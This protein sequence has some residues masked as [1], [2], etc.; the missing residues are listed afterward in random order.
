VLPTLPADTT[1]HVGAVGAVLEVVPAGCRQGGLQLLRPFPVGPCESPDLVRHRAEVAEHLP[2]WLAV[3][4]RV[5]ELLPHFD[6]E[7]LLR[8][9]SP[10]SSLVVGMRSTALGAV[11]SGVPARV[12]A[13]R[14][15]PTHLTCA[16]S[17]DFAVEVVPG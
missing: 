15:L 2:E 8:S 5:E 11:A 7:P 4:D 12:G 6:W 13:V 14:R 17:T 1:R 3:V 16:I 10:A 9:D